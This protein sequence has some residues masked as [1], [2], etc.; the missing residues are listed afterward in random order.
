MKRI[1]ILIPGRSFP[2]WIAIYL[3]LFFNI[4]PEVP[5]PSDWFGEVEIGK[6]SKA[7]RQLHL[8]KKSKE[9]RFIFYELSFNP[10]RKYEELRISGHIVEQPKEIR[11]LVDKCALYAKREFE[12]RWALIRAYDCNHLVF[13]IEKG[14]KK[15]VLLKEE[16]EAFPDIPLKLIARE[17]GINLRVL[18]IEKDRIVGWGIHSRR[19]LKQKTGFY[20]FENGTKGREIKI[21]SPRES[22][23][24]FEKSEPLSEY[25]WIPEQKYDSFLEE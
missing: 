4:F 12:K 3:L 11:F 13:L 22:N 19:V 23:V 21:L 25:I 10:I 6:E 9:H 20:L 1:K 8:F 14:F 17:K 15:E 16:R 24:F 5:Y 18:E 7:W 2:I